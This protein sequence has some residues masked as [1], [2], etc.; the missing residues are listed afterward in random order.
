[1]SEIPQDLYIT[2]YNI[3]YI[4]DLYAGCIASLFLASFSEEACSCFELADSCF[5]LADSCFVITFIS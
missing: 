5:E 1:M 4:E 2:I 3:R